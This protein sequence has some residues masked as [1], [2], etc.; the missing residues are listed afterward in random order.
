MSALTIRPVTTAADLAAVVDLC[1]AYRDFLYLF[2][3]TE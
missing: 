1:W 2:G 3:P